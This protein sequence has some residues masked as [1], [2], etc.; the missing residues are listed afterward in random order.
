MENSRTSSC[1]G[2]QPIADA[3]IDIGV[4]IR[5]KDRVSS[6]SWIEVI[7]D[8]SLRPGLVARTK[9]FTKVILY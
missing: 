7:Y 6:L 4:C 3:P 2:R 1:G 9:L 8:W 5:L